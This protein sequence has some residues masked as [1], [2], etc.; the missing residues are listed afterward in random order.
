MQRNVAGE[1]FST[2]REGDLGNPD[3]IQSCIR[4]SLATGYL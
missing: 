1:R 2:A 4:H 3:L